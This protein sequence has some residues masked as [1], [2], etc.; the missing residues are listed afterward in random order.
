MKTL[1][2]HPKDNTTDFLS[3]IYSQMENYTLIDNYIG[4]RKLK[5]AIKEHDRVIMMGH[6][7]K[8]GL[9]IPQECDYIIDSSF[10]HLLREKPESVYIWCNADM[11][12]KE[13]GLKG[14]VTGMIISEMEE[15]MMYCV[16]YHKDTLTE[17]N[18]KFAETIQQSINLEPQLMSEAVKLGYQSIDNPIMDFNRENIYHF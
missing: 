10:V 13:Y 17:S 6:G 3:I 12:V 1:I 15:A 9:W 2:I 11:F 8:H 14:F 5:E 18:D 4:D 7:G 16:P